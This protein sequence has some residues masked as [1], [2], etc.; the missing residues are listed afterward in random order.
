MTTAIVVI[1]I[2]VALLA[3]TVLSLRRSAKTGMPGPD[4]LKRATQRA[5]E[6]DAQDRAEDR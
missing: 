1:V 2:V 3:G 4:V 6:L 5:R